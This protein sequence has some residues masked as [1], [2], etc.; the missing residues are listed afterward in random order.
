MDKELKKEIRRASNINS[1]TIIVF[2]AIMF[3]AS[4]MSVIVSRL[5]V[6]KNSEYYGGVNTLI[7]Y[8]SIYIIGV[9]VVLI[10]ANALRKGSG[11][12][13]RDGF[14]KPEQSAGW[15][16][17]WIIIILGLTYMM[18]YISNIIFSIIQFLTG[19]ELH[20]ARISTDENLVSKASTFFS[21]V[22]L[23]PIFE[24]LL[25]RASLYRSS[26]KYGGWSMIILG[27]LTF[28]LW[29]GNYEQ[30]LYTATLGVF[31]CFLTAKTRSVFPSIILHFC[32]NLIAGL[33]LLLIDQEAFKDADGFFSSFIISIIFIA[34]IFMLMI[35]AF[36]LL[37]IEITSDRRSFIVENAL[38][39]VKGYKKFFTYL[40][41][42]LTILMLA[43]LIGFTAIMAL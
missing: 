21:V 13:L 40:T 16:F 42:P 30:T 1:L 26:Q 38:P 23:A 39:E 6:G 29:H 5:I 18:S 41:A 32:L 35:A 34:F 33:Q 43:G 10:M 27:G 37:L 28:G 36:V 9:P 2:Y 15:V 8:V 3:A 19:V 14:R 31:S 4:I 11:F 12:R 20:P 25:F 22:I 7:T 24:E 17:K